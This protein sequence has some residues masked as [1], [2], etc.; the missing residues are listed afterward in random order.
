MKKENVKKIGILS[1]ILCILS[2]I[3]IFILK[4]ENNLT[5]SISYRGKKYICLEYNMD[6]FTYNF[7]SN[8]YYEEDIIHPI[9]HDKWDMVYFNGDLFIEEESIKAAKVYYSND[10][11]YEWF[12]VFDENDSQITIPIELTEEE[13]KYIYNM[14]NMK[15]TETMTFEEIKMFADI[16]KISKDKKVFSLISLANYKGSWYW[17]TEIMTDDKAID[18]EYIIKLPESLNNKISMIIKDY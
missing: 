2:I 10:K 12:I 1:I 4:A 13:I 9:L 16:T 6:I 17:K 8:D 11:N 5:D 14:D 7:N 15:K 18:E 3:L